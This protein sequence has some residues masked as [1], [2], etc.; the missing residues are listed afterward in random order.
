MRPLLL[1]FL[2]TLA[3]ACT[4]A[5]PPGTAADRVTA[6]VGAT[7]IH[8][9]RDGADAVA[10]STTI[11]VRGSRIAAVG[12][13]A[14]TPVP[15]GAE[16]IDARGRWVIPGLVDAHVHFF[17]S[18]NLYTRPDAMDFNAVV[19]YAQEVARN[20]ARLPET[21]RVWLRSGVTSVA[22]VGGPFWNFDVRDAAARNPAAPRVAIAGPLISM[23]DRV[24]LD[25]GD[26]PII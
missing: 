26:P 4:P 5:D 2:A 14:S 7:V 8:P 15:A 21:F 18:G 9:E 24:K 10:A 12:P 17:Q 20:K 23:V 13:A 16:V 3:V 22:D 1:S 19:P 25:L 6:I 11:V